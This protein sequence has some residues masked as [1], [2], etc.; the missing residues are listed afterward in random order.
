MEVITLV[1]EALAS[2]PNL[3]ILAAGP[4]VAALF[5]IAVG[6]FAADVGAKVRR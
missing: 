2:L 1:S 6:R 3:G 4:V 5:G